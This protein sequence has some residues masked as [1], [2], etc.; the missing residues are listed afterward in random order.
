MIFFFHLKK[1]LFHHC[2]SATTYTLLL[3]QQLL[4]QCQFSKNNKNY[5][6]MEERKKK[7]QHQQQPDKKCEVINI[8]L[9][10]KLPK[11]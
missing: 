9:R 2:Y 3:W 6:N 10:Q 11:K 4:Y 5:K 1:D 7:E 8:Y